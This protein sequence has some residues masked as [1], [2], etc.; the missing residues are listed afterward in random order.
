MAHC[1]NPGQLS[2]F[3]MA[4]PTHHFAGPVSV[5]P[6]TSTILPLATI[7]DSDFGTLVIIAGIRSMQID[8]WEVAVHKVACKVKVPKPEEAKLP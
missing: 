6:G 8:R 3:A 7:G 4:Q 1:N 2:T 5:G